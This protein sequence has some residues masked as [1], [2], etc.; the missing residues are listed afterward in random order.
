VI[1]GEVFKMGNWFRPE[2]LEQLMELLRSFDG[3]VKYR[4]VAG[5]TGTGKIVLPYKH[6]SSLQS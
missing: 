3:S 4:L 5:N 1:D 2:S 6:R